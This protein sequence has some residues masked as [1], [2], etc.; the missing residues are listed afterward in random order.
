VESF[1]GR[2]RDECLSKTNFGALAH[3][4]WLLA[5]WRDDYNNL[6]THGGVGGLTPLVILR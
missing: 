4:R 5:A 1:I 3:A 6:R 2:L